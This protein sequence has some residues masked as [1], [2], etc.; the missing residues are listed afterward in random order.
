MKWNHEYESQYGLIMGVDE[1]GRGCLAGPVVS[2]AVV[3]PAGVYI[4]GVRDSKK[5]SAKKREKLAEKIKRQALAIGIG[6][7]QP[8]EIDQI[9]IRPSVQKTMACA[10]DQVIAQ[11]V[12]PGAICVDYETVPYP[13]KQQS[14]VHGDATI[15][16]IACAS[17]VAKV[18]RDAMA[19]AWDKEHPGYFFAK[20]KGYGTKAHKEGIFERGLSP[21]HRK[22]FCKFW[23]ETC[24]KSL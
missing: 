2:C 23:S 19:E 20:N 3:M 9:G 6:V 8:E 12:Y 21:L 5:L 10:C 4:Q 1:V 18:Y 11:G 17:I 15:Y 22:S 14:V 13:W 24:D 16:A 7:V